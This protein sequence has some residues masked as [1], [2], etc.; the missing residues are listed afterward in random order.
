VVYIEPPRLV[1]ISTVVNQYTSIAFAE[2]LVLERI[3]ASIGASA[4][5]MTIGLIKTEALCPGRPFRSGP[6]KAHQVPLN[7]VGRRVAEAY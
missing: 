6:L 7:G 3:T 1:P 4:T 2:T 5:R